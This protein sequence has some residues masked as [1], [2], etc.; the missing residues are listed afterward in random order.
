MYRLFIL[1]SS[2]L[3]FSIIS[4]KVQF[5]FFVKLFINGQLMVNFQGILRSFKLVYNEIKLLKCII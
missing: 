3:K 5:Q 4:V 2:Q 1:K